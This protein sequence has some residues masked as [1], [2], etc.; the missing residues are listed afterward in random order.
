MTKKFWN[1]EVPNGSTDNDHGHIKGFYGLDQSEGFIVDHSAPKFPT[2]NS[3]G[4]VE[5]TYP[6]SASRYG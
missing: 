5:L 1:D 6:S 2:V 4:D 3:N